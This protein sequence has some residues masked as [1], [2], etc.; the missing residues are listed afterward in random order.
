[1]LR[2]KAKR[3]EA[4]GLG[5]FVDTR[6]SRKRSSEIENP[7]SAEYDVEE[8]LESLVFG[9]QP[10]Q[11]LARALSSSGEVSVSLI[12]HRSLFLLSALFLP[13]DAE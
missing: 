4:K 1:M 9:K 12:T 5:A 7:A 11:P 13:F 10:F 2:R 6:G 3:E 8:K